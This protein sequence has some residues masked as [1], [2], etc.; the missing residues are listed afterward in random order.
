[1]INVEKRD[2][3]DILL[4]PYWTDFNGN[5][6]NKETKMQWV[7]LLSK[8]AFSALFKTKVAEVHIPSD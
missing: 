4:L 8:C 3:I 7:V 6:S 1:M 2:D 5:F